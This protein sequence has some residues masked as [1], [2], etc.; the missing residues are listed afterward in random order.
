MTLAT[1][2]S[3]RQAR[4]DRARR[5]PATAAAAGAHGQHGLDDLAVAGAAA[6][7]AAQRILDLGPR[8]RAAVAQ[9]ILRRHQHARRADAALRRAMVE[10]GLLQ[11]RERA[12]RRKALDRLDRAAGHLAHRDQ[13]GADLPAVEQHRAGAAVAGVAADL[14]AGEAEIVAQ[15]GGETRDRRAPS[16]SAVDAVQGEGDLHARSPA[17]GGA[18]A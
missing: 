1:P 7:H 10:E 11:R 6:E 12:V 4:A 3:A 18:A 17:A 15:R 5:R 9:Q 2:S 16:Q 14:G 8:R 13:A